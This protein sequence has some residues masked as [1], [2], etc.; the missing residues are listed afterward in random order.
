MY[1]IP[2]GTVVKVTSYTNGK[3]EII[4][5]N[6][7]GKVTDTWIGSLMYERLG[8]L[9]VGDSVVDKAYLESLNIENEIETEISDDQFADPEDYFD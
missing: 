5:E 9:H 4:V 2:Y 6:A 7:N 1:G 8:V 3:T